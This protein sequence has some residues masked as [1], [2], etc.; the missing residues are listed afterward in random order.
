MPPVA[1]ASDT[2]VIVGLGNPGPKH[3]AD[4]HNVGFWFVDQ[5]AAHLGG[6][7]ASEARFEAEECRVTM[8]GRTV[9]LVKPATFMNRSG[10]SARKVLDYYAVPPEQLLVVHDELDLSPGTARLKKGGGH[11]GHNGLRD[12]VATCGADFLRLRLGIGHPGHKDLVTDYVL[13]APGKAERAQILDAM[14]EALPAVEILAASGLEK[15]MQRLHTSTPRTDATGEFG[16][17]G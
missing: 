15:A 2:L 3:A 10:R 6:R 5:L 11:G 16:P 12:I 14:A 17:A 7:F 1:S 9:R 4:R 13:H 8:S